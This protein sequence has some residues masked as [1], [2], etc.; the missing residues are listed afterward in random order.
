MHVSARN[1]FSGKVKAVKLGNVMAEVTIDIGGGLRGGSH[2]PQARQRRHVPGAPPALQR[3][4]DRR[5]HL[6]ERG[7]QLLQWLNRDSR[8]VRRKQG[9]GDLSL[10]SHIGILA[11]C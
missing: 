1:Q 11:G 10:Q 9:E 4:G 5:D 7:A 2:A 8:E 6:P 3:A